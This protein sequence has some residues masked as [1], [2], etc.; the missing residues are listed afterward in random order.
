MQTR[1]KKTRESHHFLVS[2]SSENP[3]VQRALKT[4]SSVVSIQAK[5]APQTHT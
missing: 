5:K 3:R 2:E 4:D 1:Y